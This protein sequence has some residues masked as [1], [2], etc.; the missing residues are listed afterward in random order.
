MSKSVGLKKKR[1][2]TIE[3]QSFIF[4]EDMKRIRK[5][6]DV[7][8]HAEAKFGVLSR[9]PQGRLVPLLQV[10]GQSWSQPGVSFVD[11]FCSTGIDKKSRS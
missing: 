9:D 4:N 7:I 11:S 6:E 8:L 2:N 1:Q 10:G 5:A 3:G